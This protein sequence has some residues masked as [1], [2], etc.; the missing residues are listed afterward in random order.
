MGKAALATQVPRDEAEQ[1]LLVSRWGLFPSRFAPGFTRPTDVLREDLVRLL[2]AARDRLVSVIAPA[3]YGKTTL[4][5]QHVDA[6]A[7][8][9]AWLT[10]GLDCNDRTTLARY[11]ALTLLPITPIPE[12]LMREL[13]AMRQRRGALEAG[14]GA[15][16]GQ[17]SPFTLVLD[18]AHLL[19]DRPCVELMGSLFAEI[20]DGAQVLLAGRYET[21]IPLAMVRSRGD[22]LELGIEELRFG[23]DDAGRLLRSAGASSIS[24]E[25]VVSVTEQTEGWAVGL[26]LTARSWTDEQRAPRSMRGDDR[27][28]A[29]YLREA[30]L[31]ELPA[32]QIEFL[33]ESS[34]LEVLTGPLCDAA[35]DRTGSGALLQ[36][37]EASNLLVV[38]LD[39]QRRSY[40]YHNLLREMLRRELED[41]SPH[42][43]GPITAR[44]SA[45]WEQ[46]GSVERAIT[47]AMIGRHIDRVAE[48]IERHMHA[49]YYG[50]RAGSVRAW[51]TWFRA[52]ARIERYP[53]V[54]VL[55]MFSSCLDGNAV[56]A[57]L[58][59]EGASGPLDATMEGVRSLARAVMCRDGVERMLA[60]AEHAASLIDPRSP[61]R[62]AAATMPGLALH[63]LGRREEA[64]EVLEEGLRVG[65]EFGVGPAQVVAHVELGVLALEHGEVDAASRHAVQAHQIIEERSLEGYYVHVL[66]SSLSARV[67]LVQGDPERAR[68]SLNEALSIEPG[69][70]YATPTFAVRS[71]ILLARCALGLGDTPLAETIL[72]DADEVLAERP[73]LG[74]LV[75]ELTE[76]RAQIASVKASATGAP[77]L[78][79]AEARLLPL[80]STYL[81]FREIAD[82][83]FVSPNTVKTQAISIYRKLGVSSRGAAIV[84]ARQLG[85]LA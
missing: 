84:A 37:L 6:D 75:D 2:G 19:Y 13:G 18:D 34:V 63:A 35:L 52:N 3:G 40:R 54:A 14:L 64:V 5:V 44:A 11:L 25:E 67:R 60:E 79:R 4:L 59:A 65:E 15:M 56:E 55:A 16:I 46:E 41:R 21:S 43:I 26:Y 68:W 74:I 27:H 29:D 12:S 24:E 66:A 48:L 81:S 77:R 36:A 33:L 69:L 47:Y 85:L 80:L 71:S 51:L 50:G 82:Q 45:W 28:I 9:S 32:D 42:L 23:T 73:L 76:I 39:H 83:L 53:R 38:P 57:D 7:R 78:T 31:D 58:W 62:A 49:A 61:F 72:A 1:S 10:I 70:S 17:A 8:P 22:L 20:P 30:M